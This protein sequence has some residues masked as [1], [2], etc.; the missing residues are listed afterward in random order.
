MYGLFYWFF[1]IFFVVLVCIE[2][3]GKCY[4]Y[5]R[6]YVSLFDCEESIF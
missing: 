6:E 2:V 5:F 1:S 4:R 3:G